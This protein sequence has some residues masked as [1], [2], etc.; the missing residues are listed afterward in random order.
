MDEVDEVIEIDWEQSIEDGLKYAAREL[1]KILG[2]KEPSDEKLKEGLDVARGYKPTTIKSD[3]KV[4]K[5]KGKSIRYFA[6]LPEVDVLPILEHTFKEVEEQGS[7]FFEQLKNANR[8]TKRPHITLVHRNSLSKEADEDGTNDRALWDRSEILHGMEIPPDFE[9][10]L[11]NVLWDGRVMVIV[12]DDLKVQ[13]STSDEGHKGEEFVREL[14][15]GVRDR[16]HIT[17][18]TLN[19]NIPP[20]EAKALV[21]RWKGGETEGILE[22]KLKGEDLVVVGRVKGMQY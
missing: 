11:T 3:D 18:G 19:D 20:V 15:S 10:K 5:A 16:L 8:I 12:V 17:V 21:E 6:L 14:P 1:C 13:N 22:A 2:L 4:K 7:E 9:L